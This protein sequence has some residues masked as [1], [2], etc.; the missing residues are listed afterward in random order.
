MQLKIQKSAAIR[1]VR[2]RELCMRWQSASMKSSP[3]LKVCYLIR[4]SGIQALQKAASRLDACIGLFSAADLLGIGHVSG[5]LPQL[6]V[7]KLESAV[8]P[9]SGLLP[10]GAQDQPDIVLK[11]ANAPN[12][13]FRGAVRVGDAWVCDVLQIWLDA[14]AHPSRGLEQ[15]E[16]LGQTVL[17]NVIEGQE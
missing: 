10:A 12:S 1:V 3:E 4:S 11:Q 16:F 13:I 5:A 15:A 17:A 9:S 7:R 14:S 2:R 8:G 6:Y